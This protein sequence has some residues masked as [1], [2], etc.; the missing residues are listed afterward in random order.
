MKI[1]CNVYTTLYYH[2]QYYSL[3]NVYWTAIMIIDTILGAE[4]TPVKKAKL[5][6]FMDFIPMEGHR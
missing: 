5:S 4:D 1:A 3:I 6:T 2:N